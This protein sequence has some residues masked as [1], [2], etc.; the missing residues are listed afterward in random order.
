MFDMQRTPL[1]TLPAAPPAERPAVLDRT[2]A[3]LLEAAGE[4]FAESGYYAATIREIAHRARANVAAVNYHFGDKL[5]LYSEVLRQSVQGAARNE[6][7]R[8]AFESDSPP[9]E[10][11]RKVIRTMLHTVCA[12]E[13][14]DRRLGLMMHEL[15]QPTP[16]M[17]RVI[18]E[19]M[20]PIYQRLRQLIGAMIGLPDDHEKTRLCTHSIVGQ[21]VHYAHARPILARLWPEFTMAPQQLDR[22]AQHIA[23]F[24][25][26]YLSE[27]HA[28]REEV[29]PPHVR[30]RK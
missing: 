10:V 21:I 29:A 16:A 25:L 22:I 27:M 14:R 28:R 11:L 30:T 1:K 8:A 5:E 6:A 23:D 15:A 3:K 12:A 7:I 19:T 4:V 2:R 26:A 17:S 20:A 13:H 18:D 24:S 9:E